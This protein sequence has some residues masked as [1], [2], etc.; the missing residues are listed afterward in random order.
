MLFFKY[1]ILEFS[2]IA[3]SDEKKVFLLARQ[4]NTCTDI[5]IFV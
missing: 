5:E 4:C 1:F 2:K 3:M